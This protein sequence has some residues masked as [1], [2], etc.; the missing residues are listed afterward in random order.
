MANNVHKPNSNIYSNK[1]ISQAPLPPCRDH[2]HKN[3]QPIPTIIAKDRPNTNENKNKNKN[4]NKQA[5]PPKTKPPKN[6]NKKKQN[7]A[8]T[9]EQKAAR[10]QACAPLPN[11]LIQIQLSKFLKR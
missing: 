5:T 1:P 3:N 2:Q 6:N 11:Y 9:P 4:K 10:A 7:K 8:I